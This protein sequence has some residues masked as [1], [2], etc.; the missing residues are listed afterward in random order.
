L[1]PHAVQGLLV[2]LQLHHA[3]AIEFLFVASFWAASISFLAKASQ[4]GAWAF[5]L[6]AASAQASQK[7]SAFRLALKGITRAL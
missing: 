4:L 3:V 6:A 2:V 5:L 7:R 1:L